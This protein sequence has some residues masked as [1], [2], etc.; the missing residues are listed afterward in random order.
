MFSHYDHIPKFIYVVFS[1][2]FH[3]SM[4][5]L[6]MLV[7]LFRIALVAIAIKPFK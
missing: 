3:F 2:I 5:I 6:T 7:E 1:I 4:Q